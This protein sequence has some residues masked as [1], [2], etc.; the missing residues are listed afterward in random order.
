MISWVTARAGQGRARIRD[1]V[2]NSMT[3]ISSPCD[4][5]VRFKGARAES[6]LCKGTFD[7]GF[8]SCLGHRDD[9]VPCRTDI[10]CPSAQPILLQAPYPA[11]G[12]AVVPL[13][14][15]SLIVK[16]TLMMQ[17]LNAHTDQKT[18]AEE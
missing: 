8:P 18:I 7:R 1:G 9:T 5:V 3:G 13:P 2:P 6:S 11:Q 17:R 16:E 10:S 14:G 15:A 4:A 12:R